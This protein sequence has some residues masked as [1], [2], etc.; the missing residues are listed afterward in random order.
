MKNVT[1][2]VV[3]GLPNH[4]GKIFP[5]IGN[6]DTYPQDVFSMSDLDKAF[7]KWAP[8][9]LQFIDDEESQQSFLKNQYFAKQLNEKARVLAINTNICYLENWDSVTAFNDPAGQLQWLID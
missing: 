1:K 6:H 8:E 5:T 3:E 9:W 7:M 2:T 4:K